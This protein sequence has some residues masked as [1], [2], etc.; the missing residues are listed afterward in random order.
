MNALNDKFGEIYTVPR[1]RCLKCGDPLSSPPA[2]NTGQA[3]WCR[4]CQWL[5][6]DPNSLSLERYNP[7]PPDPATVKALGLSPSFLDRSYDEP[8][9]SVVDVESWPELFPSPP[10]SFD[11]L[12]AA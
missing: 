5:L 12:F 7:S 3:S 8:I 6:R 1:T 2:T 9:P 10:P 4:T 11:R